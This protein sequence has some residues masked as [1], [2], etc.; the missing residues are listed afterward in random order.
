MDVSATRR[1][2]VLSLGARLGGLAYPLTALALVLGAWE[3]WV[4]VGDVK[5]YVMTS[6]SDVIATCIRQSDL[7]LSDAFVTLTEAL[8]G[9]AAAIVLGVALAFLIVSSRFAERG[10]YPVVVAFHVVPVIAI[11]PLL[12]IWFGYDLT[13]K[14]VIVTLITFFP[15]MVNAIIG[16]RATTR[17]ELYL[18]RTMGAGPGLTFWQLR[19][20]RALPQLFAGLKLAS[21]LA[22]IGAVVAE[23]VS[24]TEG[25]GYRIIEANGNLDTEKL[26][27]S[28]LYLGV[29][30][31]LLYGAVELAERFAIPWHASR[32]TQ[33]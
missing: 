7:F 17:Q 15:I 24:A 2:V 23:F 33:R 8:I 20:R 4:R 19:L 32:R 10:L 26:M 29:A 31:I 27:A 14:V 1:A 3:L 25:L 11:A 30:G 5:P 21:T 6:F 16:M 9:F 28:V 13:P 18:F 12:L 22:L